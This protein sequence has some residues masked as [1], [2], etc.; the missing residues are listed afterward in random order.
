MR[1]VTP[2]PCG[3]RGPLFG[4]TP[5]LRRHLLL[6]KRGHGSL[7]REEQGLCGE[8]LLVGEPS[9][10]GS[11]PSVR[12]HPQRGKP[13]TPVTTPSGASQG[14]AQRPLGL[15]KV[16]LALTLSFAPAGLASEDP[17]HYAH[18]YTIPTQ[19]SQEK[20]GGNFTFSLLPSPPCSWAYPYCEAAVAPLPPSAISRVFCQRQAGTRCI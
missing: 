10:E 12:H 5:S 7:S 2:S 8:R 6:C 15:G 13:Q 1:R 9:P 3:V 20:N 11:V 19:T 18:H 17:L 14:Q 16:A 4:S